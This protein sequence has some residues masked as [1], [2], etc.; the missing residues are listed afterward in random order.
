MNPV[1]PASLSCTLRVFVVNARLAIRATLHP[2]FLL[3]RVLG[4]FHHFPSRCELSSSCLSLI[5]VLTRSPTFTF[6]VVDPYQV[7]QPSAAWPSF[8]TASAFAPPTLP[9]QRQIERPSLVYTTSHGSLPLFSSATVSL[10]LVC[11]CTKVIVVCLLLSSGHNHP[12]LF[13]R[14]S[15][16]FLT[17]LHHDQVHHRGLPLTANNFLL[18]NTSSS[19]ISPIC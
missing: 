18:C 7:C 1:S 6:S 15:S 9:W 12:D 4:A 3:L 10:R 8:K 5:V 16:C 13:H 19:A 11:V 14:W 17:H 2:L